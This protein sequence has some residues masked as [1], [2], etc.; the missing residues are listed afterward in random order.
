MNLSEI[1]WDIDASGTW[2]TPVKAS[3]IGLI[4]LLLAGAWFYFDT[5]GQ[6]NQLETSQKL[7]ADFKRDFEKKQSQA[8]NLQDYEYQLTQIEAELYEMIR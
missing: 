8:I 5:L 7:E 2:P 3:V 4:C 6:L 1:N